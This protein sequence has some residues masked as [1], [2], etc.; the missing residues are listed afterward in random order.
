MRLSPQATA[1]SRNLTS[2][3]PTSRPRSRPR[4]ISRSNAAASAQ[5]IAQATLDG[6]NRHYELFRDCAR[7]AKDYFE[8]GNWLAIG[9]VSR[10]RIDFYDRRVGETVALLEGDFGCA[11]IDDCRWAEVKRHYIALLIDHQ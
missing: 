8:V 1:R 9:H 10:D 2:L 5:A 4:R 7:L 3:R 11:S 6:F